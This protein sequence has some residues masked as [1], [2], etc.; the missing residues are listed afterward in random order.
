[1]TGA[2]DFNAYEA[3]GAEGTARVGA[4]VGYGGDL[5]PSRFTVYEDPN[6]PRKVVPRPVDKVLSQQ[7]YSCMNPGCSWS[8]LVEGK[9]APHIEE[10]KKAREQYA[11][12]AG[13]MTESRVKALI[14]EA[15]APVLDALNQV[16]MVIAPKKRGRPAKPKSEKKRESRVTHHPPAE[17]GG[18][19]PEPEVE[20]EDPKVGASPE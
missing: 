10:C 6:A 3:E 4:R 18:P 2:N 12:E 13:A 11:K 8:T 5:S 14:K 17:E 15:Q 19:L 16:L 20:P 1:M 9:L 7:T